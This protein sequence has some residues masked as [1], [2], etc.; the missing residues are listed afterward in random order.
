LPAVVLAVVACFLNEERLLPRFL[1]SLAA[2]TRPPDELLLVDDGSDDG[3]VALAHEFASQHPWARL[4]ERPRRPPERDRLA[5]AAELRA[6]QEAVP[7]IA[8]DWELVCKMDADLEL[9]P[10]HIE[11]VVRAFEDDP[12]LGV[13]GAYLAVETPAG[14]VREDHPPHHVRGPNKFYRR[15]CFEQVFPLAPILGWDTTDELAARA[16]GWDT[17]ALVLAG[18]DSLHLR[19]TGE[20]GGSL[21][22]F[23][24][25]GVCAWG[26]GA[27]PAYVAA[28]AVS[29]MRRRPWVLGGVQY[30]AG[31]L[32]AALRRLPRA[33]ERS[34][35]QARR[36]EL[37]AL[38]SL[39]RRAGGRSAGAGPRAGTGSR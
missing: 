5:S 24:R 17:R 6:F 18:G 38:R 9:Q 21:R 7:L 16:G 32:G 25:H 34:R 4:V 29:R 36:E 14:P 11:Q 3:S 35:A 15:P 30:F 8:A 33:D 28:G 31:W 2:Q 20:H 22:A 39:S 1:A 37:A 13:T 23:R 27:H 26:F 10:Q 12:R 19:P